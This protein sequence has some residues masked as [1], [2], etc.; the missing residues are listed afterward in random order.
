MLGPDSIQ[1]S[2]KAVSYNI[3]VEKSGYYYLTLKYFK[4]SALQQVIEIY[5]L[6]EKSLIKKLLASLLNTHLLG[7]T[8]PYHQA[9]EG[10]LRLF[11][12]M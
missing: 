11:R 12:K 2:G 3:K 1:E 9:M 8:S 5:M 7:K 10:R 4:M 6:M